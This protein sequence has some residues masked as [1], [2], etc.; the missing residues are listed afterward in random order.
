MK[1]PVFNGSLKREKSD[2]M[3][4]TRTFLAGMND[5]A[6]R[7]TTFIDVI[8]KKTEYCTGCFTGKRNGGH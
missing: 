7:E 6:P 8:D 3:H 5:F 2:T 4:V 1:I